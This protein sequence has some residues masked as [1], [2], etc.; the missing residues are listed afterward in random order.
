MMRARLPSLVRAL[1]AGLAIASAGCGK[2]APKPAP[3]PPVVG[4]VTA[5]SGTVPVDIVLPGRTSPYLTSQVRPQVSGL[6]LERLFTEGSLV[7]AGQPLYRIDP[8]LYRAAVGQA[9]G[10]LASARANAVAQRQRARRY[11][12][13]EAI[14]AVARQ[15]A[16]D[17]RAS[18]GQAAAAIQQTGAA[19]ESARV[20]LAF[21]TIRAPITGRIGRSL[22]TAG[23]LVTASQTDP[24][25][26]IQRLD[27]IFV[28]IQ[29]SSSQLLALRR[30]LASG[31]V[32]PARAPVKLTLE[33][34]SPYPHEGSLL[35]ADVTVNPATGAVA[36][37]AR[38]PN[39]YGLLLPGMFVRA[40]ITQ[41]RRPDVI[42]LP[43]QAV[44]TDPRGGASV[45]VVGADG[46]V[47]ERKVETQG[48]QGGAWRVTGGL[49][50]G[51][52]VVIEGSTNARPGTTVKAVPATGKPEESAIVAPQP[53]AEKNGT[54]QG[55]G[56][57]AGAR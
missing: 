12:E 19:L 9:E 4:V 46:K 51:E 27:P 56:S 39:P 3:P 57:A 37:R 33:D 45:L 22:V 7:H 13:L 53:P 40:I 26:L 36:L 8:R 23:A 42:S 52:R 11:S 54:R 55:S 41:A 30:A 50:P 34:G 28:D 2:E 21:T 25:T 44:K 14:N 29:Q 48:L 38:F 35:F 24:L 15:D 31:G 6:L 18:A 49:K 43:P 47:E 5:R 20:N 1:P 16:D 10:N 17:A 32:L